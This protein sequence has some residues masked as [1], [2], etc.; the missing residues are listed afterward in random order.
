MPFSTKTSRSGD[1]VAIPKNEYLRLKKLDK[2][3]KD[4][5]SYFEHL[6]GIREAREEVKQGKMISQ[7]KLF[8]QL[9]F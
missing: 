2:R 9:G 8:K 1:N 5:L 4:L 3:F 6:S 7:E